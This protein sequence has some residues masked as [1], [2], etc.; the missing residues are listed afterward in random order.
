MSERVSK[1]GRKGGKEN[2]AV[3]TIWRCEGAWQVTLLNEH[4]AWSRLVETGRDCDQWLGDVTNTL[5]SHSVVAAEGG[6]VACKCA[7]GAAKL[8]KGDRAQIATLQ[9]HGK[10]R[11][12]SF[13]P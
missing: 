10:G 7:Q 11:E 4:A 2:N 12:M 6:F 8:S 5:V 13:E 3:G 9:L 1:G